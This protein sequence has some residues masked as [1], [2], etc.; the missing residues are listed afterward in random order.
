LLVQLLVAFPALYHNQACYCGLLVQLQQEEG[1]VPLGKVRV[2][3]GS[4]SSRAYVCVDMF[5][6]SLDMQQ[7]LKEGDVP[8]GKVRVAA[9][10]SSSRACVCLLWPRHAAA[11]ADRDGPLGQWSSQVKPHV[12][13]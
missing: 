11:D 3:A 5:G 4:S 12:F 1:D 8:L 9:G 13:D 7:Q 10:S 2:A 6:V